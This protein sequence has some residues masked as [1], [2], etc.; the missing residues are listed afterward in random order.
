VKTP[1][2]FIAFHRPET[3]RRVFDAIRQARPE[4]LFVAQDALGGKAADPVQ[5]QR[6]AQVREILGAVDWPCEVNTFFEN[7][8]R[9]QVPGAQAAMNWFFKNVEEGIVLE[10]DC[11]PEPSFFRFCEALLEK[12][13]DDRRVSMISGDNFQDG[14]KRGEATYYFSKMHH[15]WGWASWRRTWAGT[16]FKMRELPKFLA[17]GRMTEISSDPIVRFWLKREV[18]AIYDGKI[19]CW[20]EAQIA[21]KAWNEGGV[22]IVPNVNLISNIG[23]GTEGALNCHDDFC[24]FANMKVSPVGEIIHPPKMEADRA[25]D[26]YE[27]YAMNWTLVSGRINRLLRLKS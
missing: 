5:A 2:L 16:D 20:G 12:Y 15:F 7:E 21:F 4:R 6:H 9:G 3:T 25:A 26:W 23:Y 19:P 1:V 17:A 22:C 24:K 13:R 8:N 14:R 18:K 10:D 11:L 27:F